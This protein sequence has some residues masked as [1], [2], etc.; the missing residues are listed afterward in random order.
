MSKLT[1]EYVLPFEL[2]AGASTPFNVLDF[3]LSNY[4]IPLSLLDIAENI[5]VSPKEV[6]IILNNFLQ[7]KIIKCKKDNNE[8][9]FLTNF[10]SPKTMGLFQYY[11]AVLDENLENLAYKKIIQ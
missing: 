3:F 2:I 7:Q 10:L 4:E 1:T 5:Q 6:Q 9:L 11:R 8:T